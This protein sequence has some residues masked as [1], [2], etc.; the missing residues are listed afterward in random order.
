M[1]I[2]PGDLVIPVDGQEFLFSSPEDAT[3]EIEPLSA[4]WAEDRPAIVVEVLK[5]DPPRDYEHIKVVVDD[6][7][8]WTCSDYVK[9]VCRIFKGHE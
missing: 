5:L 8:G 3:E 2:R 7:V 6:I 4:I 9:R 1:K